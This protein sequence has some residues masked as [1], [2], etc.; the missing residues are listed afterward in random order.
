M[1][2]ET[3]TGAVTAKTL[4]LSSKTRRKVSPRSFAVAVR[5]QLQNWRQGT[6]ACKGRSDVNR[7]NKKPW[8]Q[9]G[10]GRARVGT[11]R[12]PLWR[13]G[14]VTFG[15]QPRVR[16]L[17]VSKD[18]RRSVLQ[19][20]LWDKLEN[21]RIIPLE[22]NWQSDAPK[23]ADAYKALKNVG[24][25]CET[26]V[27]FV[28]PHDHRSQSSF[29]NLKN[30]SVLL[31]DQPNAYDLSRGSYWAFLQEDDKLFKEMVGAWN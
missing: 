27:L 22:I 9:K 4:G 16:K 31:F 15:P 10:T 6:V 3:K 7:T 11:A 26:V 18:V 25:D 30:V 14:G 20:L 19:E 21:S 1:A 29:A 12:S 13:G 17:S 2:N 23:T 24:L 5:A 28:A 8:K